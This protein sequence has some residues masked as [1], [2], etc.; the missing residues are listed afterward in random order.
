MSAKPLQL[1]LPL[2]RPVPQRAAGTAPCA[3]LSRRSALG[4]AA[5]GLVMTVHPASHAFFF[6]KPE[7]PAVK[8]S[9]RE[10]Y[11]AV[12]QLS[13]TQLRAWQ[14]DTTRVQ[15]LL[16]DARASAEYQVSHLNGALLTPDFKAAVQALKDRPKDTPIVVYCAV[17]VRSTA[18]ADQLRRAGWSQVSNLEGSIF[19][20]ANLGYPVVR[21]DVEVNTVHP[22]DKNWG[23]LLER[24]RWAE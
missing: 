11:P 4:W 3:P 6:S 12:P 9:M 8:Q 24:K 14:A 23:T 22:Y 21:G 18:L 16:L 19:E 2:L 13:T 10:R 20:W 15:A 17:G 1:P 5:A 7:W